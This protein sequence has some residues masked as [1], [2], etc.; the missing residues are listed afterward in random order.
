M[1]ELGDSMIKGMEEAIAFAKG[2][3]IGAVVHTPRDIKI[4]L[5]L[6]KLG[7][8]QNILA[9]KLLSHLIRR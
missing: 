8:S 3:E 1:S 5:I 4:R 7:M 9:S 6:K 2:E